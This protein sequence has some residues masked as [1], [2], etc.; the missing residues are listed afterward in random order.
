MIAAFMQPPRV[1][2]GA[3]SSPSKETPNSQ[4]L[5]YPFFL[6]YNLLVDL[7]RDATVGMPQ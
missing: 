3:E 5:S 1:L 2:K 6:S 4:V 7:E